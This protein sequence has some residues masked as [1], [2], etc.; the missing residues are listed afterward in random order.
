[1]PFVTV[2]K[3][4]RIGKPRLEAQCDVSVLPPARF[5]LKFL[6][7]LKKVLAWSTGISDVFRYALD[8]HMLRVAGAL[9]EL[10][11]VVTGLMEMAG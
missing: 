4:K 6:Y 11:R 10:E 5:R 8:C 7:A 1:M 3:Q 2:W 9:R